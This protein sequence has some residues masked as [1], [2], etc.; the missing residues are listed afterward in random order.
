MHELGEDLSNVADY[1]VNLPG[2]RKTVFYV[3]PGIAA[4]LKALAP[5]TVEGQVTDE[6]TRIFAK[7]GRSNVT[8]HAIDPG[9]LS[10]FAST[11]A[12]ARARSAMDP[13]FANDQQSLR[14]DVLGAI[15]ASTGGRLVVRTNGFE[16]AVESIFGESPVLLHGGL[17][18]CV[19]ALRRQVS[20]D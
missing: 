7:A 8:I 12:D 10:S 9:G 13:G 19:D 20:R 6:I 5:T 4:N 11:V 2:P 16:R 3:S 14:Q 1:L 17:S 18:A 15:S